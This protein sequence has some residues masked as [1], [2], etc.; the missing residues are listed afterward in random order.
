ML[1]LPLLIALVFATL[2][3]PPVL[4]YVDPDGLSIEYARQALLIPGVVI[5][6]IAAHTAAVVSPFLAFGSLV[7]NAMAFALA[8]PFFL[9]L[10]F[11]VC[12]LVLIPSAIIIRAA[13]EESLE[14]S[15]M[16]QERARLEFQA[17]IHRW[18]TVPAS[19]R[20]TF[21]SIWSY[22]NLALWIVALV[23]LLVT[24][25]FIRCHM[26]TQGPADV[27]DARL[28]EDQTAAAP[29]IHPLLWPPSPLFRAAQANVLEEAVGAVPFARAGP[30]AREVDRV[31]AQDAE[32]AVG[33][34]A[35]EPMEQ[36]P[37][38]VREVQSAAGT[39]AQLQDLFAATSA[40][41]VSFLGLA[42][43][44]ASSASSLTQRLVV[45]AR[46]SLVLR[47]LPSI[48]VLRFP[49]FWRLSL[50]PMFLAVSYVYCT[51]YCWSCV[52]RSEALTEAA[53]I[54]LVLGSVGRMAYP[55]I[56]KFVDA[57]WLEP[58]R[59]SLQ[60]SL[61][62]FGALTVEVPTWVI[63]EHTNAVA[64]ASMLRNLGSQLCSIHLPEIEDVFGYPRLGQSHEPTSLA[65]CDCV[66]AVLPRL[67][68]I[69]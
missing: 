9:L 64:Y 4:M 11:V 38:P 31:L 6:S 45:L 57:A 13:V 59:P 8:M 66:W 53:M 48:K 50:V 15:R 44:P 62:S 49:A 2:V 7:A 24:A 34:I 26:D 18:T 55:D 32:V 17:F 36:L 1:F 33:A 47:Y 65:F 20:G 54:F 3:V 39:H 19:F 23:A 10:I 46:P 5:K 12:P 56:V 21:H 41:G 30:Q 35:T 29:L 60:D 25:A 16:E 68:D 37:R 14:S 52:S 61:G 28:E 58:V 42:L 27:D 67:P 63:Q 22:R 69:F 51:L 43:P 40:S